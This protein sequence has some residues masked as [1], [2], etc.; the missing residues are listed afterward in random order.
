M[1]FTKDEIEFLEEISRLTFQDEFNSWIE[2]F[3]NSLN[4]KR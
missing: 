2:S 1:E 3:E 4:E